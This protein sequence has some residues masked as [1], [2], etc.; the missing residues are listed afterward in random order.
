MSRS[1]YTQRPTV[2][3]QVASGINHGNYLHPTSSDLFFKQGKARPQPVQHRVLSRR[4]P[5]T[6]A[7]SRAITYLPIGRPTSSFDFLTSPQSPSAFP[8]K[9]YEEKGY[10]VGAVSDHRPTELLNDIF[11]SS[12]IFDGSRDTISKMMRSL[13]STPRNE[14]VK[15]LGNR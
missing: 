7:Q 8:Y 12:A 1:N 4:L 3:T 6:P 13:G 5:P 15:I 10:G 2:T 11:Q 14:A 9:R